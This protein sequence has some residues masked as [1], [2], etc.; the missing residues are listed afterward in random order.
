[1]LYEDGTC[2]TCCP[3]GCFNLSLRVKLCQRLSTFYATEVVAPSA[4]CGVLPECALSERMKLSC[5]S[6]TYPALSLFLSP[7]PPL[8]AIDCGSCSCKDKVPATKAVEK[9]LNLNVKFTEPEYQTHSLPSRPCSCPAGDTPAKPSPKNFNVATSAVAPT[10]FC[11]AL[12]CRTARFLIKTYA[13]FFQ[14][15]PAN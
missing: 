8:S 9:F 15:V 10:S 6:H 1:M 14:I 13:H 12:A 11:G 7:S 2:C 5:T 3:R 4:A